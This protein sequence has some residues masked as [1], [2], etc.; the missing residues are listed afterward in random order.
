MRALL[1][2]ASNNPSLVRTFPSG[3]PDN[4]GVDA[5]IGRGGR[6][7]VLFD[8]KNRT[9]RSKCPPVDHVFLDS[10]RDVRDE[11]ANEH[12]VDPALADESEHKLRAPP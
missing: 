4:L 6:P 7:L 3:E 11:L 12:D 2:L 10:Q 8:A 5:A 9:P 1:S